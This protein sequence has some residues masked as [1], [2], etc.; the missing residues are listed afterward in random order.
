[1]FLSYANNYFNRNQIKEKLNAKINKGHFASSNIFSLFQS[2]LFKFTPIP[3]KPYINIIYVADLL[4]NI[5]LIYYLIV[6]V[7]ISQMKMRIF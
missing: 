6:S 7:L 1:M 2:V 4:N 3:T 5:C